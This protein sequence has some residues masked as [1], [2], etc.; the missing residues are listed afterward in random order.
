MSCA[1]SI[2]K[3][4]VNDEGDTAAIIKNLDIQET[5]VIN[6]TSEPQ[7]IKIEAKGSRRQN[8]IQIEISTPATKKAHAKATVEF[9]DRQQEQ[10]KLSSHKAST[11]SQIESLK[12]R[13]ASGLA[14][15]FT[16]SMAYRMVASLA[17]YDET[18]KSVKDC[19]LDS[20]TFEASA[21][22]ASVPSNRLPGEFALHPCV[23]D[24]IMQQANFVLNANESSRF[25]QEVYV[26]RGFETC[27]INQA[28]SDADE[29][30][31][32]V[33][34]NASDKDNSVGDVVI[35]KNKGLIGCIRGVRVQRVPRRL[36]DVMFRPKTDVGVGQ[37]PSKVTTSS[38]AATPSKLTPPPKATTPSK[39]ATQPRP[40]PIEVRPMTPPK[41]DSVKM[42]KAFTIISEES[43]IAVSDFKDDDL[44]SDL[45]I[46][47]L[48]ILV[49]ASRFR[50]ELELDLDATFFADVDSVKKIRAYFGNQNSAP[51]VS[52]DV[53]VYLDTLPPSDHEEDTISNAR[54]VSEENVVT[55]DSTK[56]ENAFSIISEESGI[57]VSDFKDDDLLA[58]L[59]IDSLLILVIA[60]RFR[61]ELE[62]DLDATF[63]ADVDSIAKIRAFFEPKRTTIISSQG[64]PGS[65]SASSGASSPKSFASSTTAASM[66]DMDDQ[67]L[68]KALPEVKEERKLPKKIAKSTSILL[69]GT[70]KPTTKT[71]FMFPDGSGSA[72]SYMHLPRVHEDVAVVAMNCPY[73]TNPH[74][75]E[76]DFLDIT[77]ILLAE[78]RRRQPKGPYY[79]GGWSAG[80]AFAYCATQ[81]LLAAGEEVKAIVLI[82]A[83][84]PIGL[85]KLPKAFFDYWRTIHQP[86]G[87]VEDRPLPSWLM[88]HFKAV[89]EN[90][91]GF[92]AEPM[93][94]GKTPKTYMVWAAK[95]TDNLAAFPG[96]HLL[97]KAESDDLGFLMDDKTDFGTR[98]WDKLLLG[99]EPIIDVAW[100]SNH[101][102]ITRGD[103]AKLVS[104]LVKQACLN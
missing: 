1:Q 77:R 13:V 9:V 98:G 89:N 49:I 33:K 59:G 63:F 99:Q 68:P 6:D 53:P 54:S 81:M 104:S 64:G 78:V 96:R 21:I 71:M 70:M 43:G 58:D 48:L 61:E 62:L 8:K 12:S 103:G 67:M 86:G 31:T 37:K 100:S 44:L 29:Y 36:M 26:I 34:M 92:V 20:K 57:A 72:T 7:I 79:L 30:E 102:T 42:E 50:E 10:Q 27:F 15:R 35:T 11:R 56:L 95:G 66:V 3:C 4:L 5:L 19:S 91:R 51:T 17:H 24:A 84:C 101:F 40:A 76:G 94:R 82:D 28:L 41:G 46:D 45:G 32:Y 69:Q 93:P 55:G 18:H 52:V 85:G 60:S 16:T 88:D 75:W 14:E 23:F 22:V 87:M 97:T 65:S 38:K 80:G 83:P 39:A 90:L 25:D 47:S 73:M 2:R 74:E